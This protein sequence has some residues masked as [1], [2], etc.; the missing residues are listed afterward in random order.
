[1]FFVD[2][3]VAKKK[4][5]CYDPDADGIFNNFTFANSCLGFD[6]LLG[7]PQLGQINIRN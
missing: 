3:N 4:Y 1:M 7:V 2:I 5:D 6:P